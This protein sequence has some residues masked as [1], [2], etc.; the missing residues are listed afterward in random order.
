MTEAIPKMTKYKINLYFVL[1]FKQ[2][3]RSVH[4]SSLSQNQHFSLLCR[5]RLRNVE[6]LK[7]LTKRTGK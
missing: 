6:V 3:P 7:V 2:L 5:V 4:C 1:E